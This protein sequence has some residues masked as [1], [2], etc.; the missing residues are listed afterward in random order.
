[1]DGWTD[2][3]IR[4]EIAAFSLPALP[5]GISTYARGAAAGV[6]Q[7]PPPPLPPRRADTEH[8]DGAGRVL[9]TCCAS[10]LTCH[11]LHAAKLAAPGEGGGC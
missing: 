7:I 9:G 10:T 8:A 3:F 4:H 1:M 5:G 2:T 11:I 6:L